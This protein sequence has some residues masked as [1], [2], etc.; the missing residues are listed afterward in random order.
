MPDD[1]GSFIAGV[2]LLLSLGWAA[3]TEM[4]DR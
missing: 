2:V 3:A 4:G 1:M